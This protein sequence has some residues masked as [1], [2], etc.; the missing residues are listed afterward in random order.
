VEHTLD[1]SPCLCARLRLCEDRVE[2]REM[3]TQLWN[4][5]RKVYYAT[6][7]AAVVAHRAQWVANPNWGAAITDV[8]GF[9]VHETSGWP[10]RAN[11]DTFNVR[12]WRGFDKLE[13]NPHPPPDKINVH[14]GATG[15]GPQYFVS[16]DGTVFSLVPESTITFHA[17]VSNSVALSGETAHSQGHSDPPIPPPSNLWRPLNGVSDRNAA[18]YDDL[19]GLKMWWRSQSFDEMVV[20]WWTTARFAGPQRGGVVE[21]EQL[22][23]EQH[24]RSW[25]LLARWAAEHFL[26]PRN[27]PLFPHK[28]GDPEPDLLDDWDL[29][30]KLLRADDGLSRSLATFG[31]TQAQVDDDAQFR[32]LYHAGLAGGVNRHWR[33]FVQHYRGFYGHG[34]TGIDAHDCPGPL[35]DWHRMARE[36]WDWWWWPFDYDA[37][38]T[39]TNVPRRPN[40]RSW[41]GDTPTAEYFFA[42]PAVSYAGRQVPG[43]HGNTGSPR[44]YRL[45]E[46]SPVYALANGELVAARFPA[47]A[48]GVSLAFVVLR[49]EVFHQ[50]HPRAG[51]DP[52][53]GQQRIAADRLDYDDPPAIVYS[54]YMHLAR[55]EGMSFDTVAAEN[56]DWLNRLLARKKEAEVGVAFH[57][58]HAAQVPSSA[59]NSRPPGDFRGLRARRPTV[60]E[61]WASDEANYTPTLNRLRGGALTVMPIDP[62][63]TPIEVLL[64]DY[65]GNAGVISRTAAGVQQSGIRVEIFSRDVV[66]TDFTLTQSSAATGWNATGAAAGAGGDDVR[67]PRV[68]GR[69]A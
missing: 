39:S 67:F 43:I 41:D 9:V 35:F 3:S 2:P 59:W 50:I 62:W 25:A 13:A 58:D 1:L 47:A 49:H 63:C 19:P 15:F 66:S 40:S 14:H 18:G 12:Y 33:T 52:A 53:A 26:I 5:L 64:G 44:T 22:F 11:V 68:W 6:V 32:G 36:V 54:L 16:G 55:P 28:L 20:S 56:P 27:F 21:P 61:S 60:L 42:T 8:R 48:T 46:G 45:E 17:S 51:L 7:E 31:W 29:F 10:A 65:L 37:A 4:R 34:F 69:T 57:R 24:Y 30:R 23:S 38:R